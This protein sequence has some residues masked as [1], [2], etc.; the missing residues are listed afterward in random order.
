LR[1]KA[2]NG[3][4]FRRQLPHYG[5][6]AD[7]CCVERKLVIELDGD[8]HAERESYDARRGELLSARGYRLLRFY[9]SELMENL[10]AVLRAIEDALQAP[11]P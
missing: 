2:A 11:S 1:R 9:N 4:R 10:A 8:S 6:I 7:Y 5:F 3:A